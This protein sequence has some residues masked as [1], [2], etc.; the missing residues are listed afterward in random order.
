MLS[1]FIGSKKDA[2]DILDAFKTTVNKKLKMEIHPE[3]SG[4]RYHSDGVLFLGYN[5]FCKYDF[6]S[7]P[8]R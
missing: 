2:F 8:R 3:K 6:S 5:L 1:G 7:P 4:V